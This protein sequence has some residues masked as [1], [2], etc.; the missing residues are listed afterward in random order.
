MAKETRLERLDKLTTKLKET[1]KNTTDWV[2]CYHGEGEFGLWRGIDNGNKF[3]V[4]SCIRAVASLGVV[5]KDPSNYTVYNQ[6]QTAEGIAALTNW[7]R[8]EL[9]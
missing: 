2:F 1:K 9:V 3:Y 7:L 6:E 5:E 4:G 8:E